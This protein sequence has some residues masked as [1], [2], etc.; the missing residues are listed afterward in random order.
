M[1]EKKFYFVIFNFGNNLYSKFVTINLNLCDFI[2]EKY[3]CIIIFIIGIIKNNNTFLYAIL[4]RCIV[5]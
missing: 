3:Q 2:E 4:L 1:M 5:S